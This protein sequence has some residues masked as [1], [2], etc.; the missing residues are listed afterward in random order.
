VNGSLEAI[1]G[2]LEGLP[3]HELSIKVV[4]SGVGPVSESDIDLA[5]TTKAKLLSFN[6]NVDKKIVS[7]AEEKQVEVV[8]QR[9]IYEL[10]DKIKDMMC[11][12][13]PPEEVVLIKGEAEVL[14]LFSISKKGK[15]S[16]TV[17]GCRILAGK[18]RKDHQVRIV[19]KG[20]ILWQGAFNKCSL[21]LIIVQD[22]LRR[23]G[24]SKKTLKRPQRAQNAEWNQRDRLICSR[25]TQS[26]R[27]KLNRI[28]VNYNI[29]HNCEIYITY[30]LVSLT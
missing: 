7:R 2:A 22:N 8:S 16:S 3:Q 24:T 10:L 21:S 11:D 27:L 15:E 26:S 17:A 29:C 14:Q 30:S 5:A 20:E 19:R 6:V 13:L 18:V 23:F 1:L 25:A 28:A 4:A 9:I 12:L